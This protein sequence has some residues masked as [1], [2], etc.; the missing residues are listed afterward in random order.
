LNFKSKERIPFFSKG[1]TTKTPISL[2]QVANQDAAKRR[3][4]HKKPSI[5]AKM[6]VPI[7]WS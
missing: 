4:R 3:L 2:V 7:R 1:H 6:R 5:L